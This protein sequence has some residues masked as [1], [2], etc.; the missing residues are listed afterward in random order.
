MGYDAA[1]RVTSVKEP[2]GVPDQIVVAFITEFA[3]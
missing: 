2:F 1:D 3:L